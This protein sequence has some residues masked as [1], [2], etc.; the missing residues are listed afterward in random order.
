M[1]KCP[2]HL[3]QCLTTSLPEDLLKNH[4]GDVLRN[5]SLLFS[6]D[7]S[8]FTAQLLSCTYLCHKLAW[9]L[10]LYS[11]LLAAVLLSTAAGHLLGITYRSPLEICLQSSALMNTAFLL[12]LVELCK[13]PL[14]LQCV[15]YAVVFW[16]NSP[17]I[18]ALSMR[19]DWGGDKAPSLGG[20]ERWVGLYAGMHLQ[21]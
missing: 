18:P 9:S 16:L 14:W 11:L 6:L 15:F 13:H 2:S 20:R 17:F 10:F 19:I 4:G 3:K 1:N 5:L 21:G 7:V 8:A 12:P